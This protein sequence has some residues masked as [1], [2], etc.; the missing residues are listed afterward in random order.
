M[1]RN[2]LKIAWRNLWKSKTFSIVNIT[3]LAVGI[4]GVLLIT[5]H[6]RH[7]LSH[8]E[9]F[10]KVDRIYRVTYESSGED[11]R[12]W[13]ATPPP[14]VPALQRAFPQIEAGVRLH[15]LFP[16]QLFSYTSPAGDVKRF[17]EKGGFLMAHHCGKTAC[18][19][20]IQEETKATIRCLPFEFVAEKGVCVRCG[21]PSERRVPFAKAY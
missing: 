15:R 13:A 1:F 19:I 16:Y 14:L 11:S 10:E 4:A 20:A 17:E 18:E 6:I 21:E 12:H 3:G 2:Y 8:E 7:E 9:G 5:F